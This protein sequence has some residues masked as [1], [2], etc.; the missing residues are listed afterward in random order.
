MNVKQENLKDT[1][2]VLKSGPFS[3]TAIFHGLLLALAISVAML[4]IGAAVIHW[5][6]TPEHYS[7]V[8]V[9]IVTLTGVLLGSRLTGR[10]IGNK[11]W[12]NGGLVGLLY[13]A[14]ILLLGFIF[15]DNFSVGLSFFSKAF[16][17]FVF[18]ALGGMWGVN[19]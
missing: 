1:A 16:L 7:S 19:S 2:A 4:L 8:L 10:R 14:A 3:L 12:L 13:V 17:G 9:F 6:N 15:I 11:G 18:G 5:T